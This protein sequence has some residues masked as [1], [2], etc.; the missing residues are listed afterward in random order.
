MK[1]QELIL[2]PCSGSKLEGGIENL[3]GRKLIEDIYQTDRLDDLRKEVANFFG[4]PTPEEFHKKPSLEA[5]KRYSGNIYG[6]ISN[7]AWSEAKTRDDL[8]IVIVSA[9]YGMIYWDEPIIKYDVAMDNSIR[10]G[11]RLNTWWRNNGLP[12]ILSSYVDKNGFELVRS[13][14]SGHYQ[15]AI[16]PAVDEVQAEW[17]RYEYPALGSGSNYY[18]GSDINDIILNRHIE[19][20]G[21]ESRKTKRITRESYKC[22]DCGQKYRV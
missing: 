10:R 13:F 16:L 8:E 9:L 20:P 22:S 18:R 4:A 12:E 19:C 5:Y 15:K 14:L 2:I 6:K 11:R 7:K 1:K 17:L 21:C 3:Q